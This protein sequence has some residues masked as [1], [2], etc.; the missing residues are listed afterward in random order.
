MGRFVRAGTRFFL[1]WLLL[2]GL[3]AA[4][5]GADTTIPKKV[6]RWESNLSLGLTGNGRIGVVKSF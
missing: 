1:L 3:L 6:S 2:S 5:P 4:A